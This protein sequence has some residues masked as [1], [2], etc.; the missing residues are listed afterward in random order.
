MPLQIRRGTTAQRLAITPLTGELIHDTTT[1]QLFVGNGTTLGGVTTTGITLEDAADTAAALFSTGSHSGITFAYND[2]AGRIDA[3]VTV[4]ATGPFDGDLTGSVFADNS[5]MLVDAVSGQI[6]GDIN[7]RLG[8]N[9]DVNGN[10]IVSSSNGDIIIAPNGSGTIQLNG[11]ITKT[12]ELNIS[13]TVGTVFGNNTTLVDGNVTI[14]RNSYS[15]ASGTGFIFQ[16]HH[17]TADAVNFTFLRSRGTALARTSVVNNDDIIDIVF[18][19]HDGTSNIAVGNINCQVDGVVSTGRI[20]TRFGFFLHDG[21]TSGVGGTR[22][23][24]QLNSAGIWKTNSI[25]AFSGTTINVVDNNNITIGDVRLN[26]DGLSTIN[27]NASLILSANGTGSVDIESVRIVGSTIS[28]T[29]S[30]GITVSQAAT[31]SSN[32]TVDGTLTVSD[33]IVQ[34][35]PNRDYVSTTLQ[36]QGVARVVSGVQNGTYTQLVTNTAETYT[37]II[38]NST[39]F[40]GCRATIKASYGDTNVFIGEVLLANT[41]TAVTIVNAEAT[42]ATIGTSPISSVTADYDSAT[43]SIRLRPVTSASLTA[44]AN[45]NWTVNYQLFT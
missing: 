6:K 34:N 45:Y 2:A 29:D 43:G 14:T 24:A 28:T 4:A 1:G 25:G 17:N 13:P 33:S 19:A 39:T 7:A 21:I 40:R 18:T 41:T 8:G 44:G 37:A 36:T 15:T 42:A 20:P 31:F 12:G 38:Y 10:S 3:T 9:L 35:N 22:E 27:T 30:S 26:A 32:V 11:N 16:Q 23:V 5:T